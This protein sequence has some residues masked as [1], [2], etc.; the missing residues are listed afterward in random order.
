MSDTETPLIE[1]GSE[2]PAVRQAPPRLGIS[3]RRLTDRQREILDQ[4][5]I[6]FL[7][8]GF[9][10][11]TIRELAD[12]LSC[13]R[14]TLYD[15]APSKDELTLFVIDRRLRRTGHHAA[16]ALQLVDD[17]AQRLRSF[18]LAGASRLRATTLRYQED[19]ANWPPAQRLIAAHHRY[20][21]A[22]VADIIQDGIDRGHFRPIRPT[23]VATVI[24]ASLERF[25]H[26]TILREQHTT[27]EDA[28]HEIVELLLPALTKPT[29]N[30]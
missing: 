19:I 15:L 22:I 10:T 20:A 21:A 23:F 4:L 13:S 17:P 30:G 5:E 28:V 8:H 25:Q 7:E 29:T 11:F 9:A 26:P 3:E 2:P 24:D 27:F 1:R 18:V 16:E 6:L 14:R 12:R